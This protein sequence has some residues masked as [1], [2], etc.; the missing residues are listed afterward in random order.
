[1]EQLN[2]F[3]KGLKNTMDP[4]LFDNES[5]TFPTMNIRVINKKGQGFVVTFYDGATNEDTFFGDEFR[6]SEGF[7]VVFVVYL[8]I[9]PQI[10]EGFFVY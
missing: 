9:V 3:T 7:F 8:L 10:F 5:W 6:L 4:T 1:M 2:L